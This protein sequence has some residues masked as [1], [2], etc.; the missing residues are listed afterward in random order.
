MYSPS[1]LDLI[2]LL[3]GKGAFLHD[4]DIPILAG[5]AEAVPDWGY[6]VEIGAAY[7]ASAVILLA[8]S[9][10]TVTVHSV[11]P[12]HIDPINHWSSTAQECRGA[13]YGA[14]SKL[15]RKDDLDRWQLIPE[16]AHDTARRLQEVNEYAGRKIDLLVI[17]GDHLLQGV[18]QDVHDWVGLVKPG[19]TI[20]L[21]DSRHNPKNPPDV[22]A[23]E[24]DRD[25]GLPGPTHVAQIMM[26]SPLVRLF[27]ARAGFSYTAWTRTGVD[28]GLTLFTTVKHFDQ[29]VNRKNQ[30]NAL[31]SWQK[32]TPR[33][34]VLV[35]CDT[36][37]VFDV[38][39][40]GGQP[41]LDYPRT[42]RGMPLVNGMFD[43]A[44]KMAL[45]NQVTFVNADITLPTNF[46]W[47]VRATQSRFMVDYM[48]VGQRWD[49]DMILW[50]FDHSEWE[51]ELERYVRMN[52]KLHAPTGK[53]FFAFQRP[54]P[55]DIPEFA[56]ARC[57]FDN[58]ILK[59]AI[60]TGMDVVDATEALFVVHGNHVNYVTGNNPLP[61][62]DDF[63]NDPEYDVNVELGGDAFS[64]GHIDQTPWILRA[65][66]RFELR[67]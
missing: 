34:Q 1:R 8:N 45:H 61:G 50:D 67:G 64:D 20:L 42:D 11:D 12:F 58:W 25:G 9:G 21:H 24:G 60:T 62:E 46:P 2:E 23:V 49:T 39:N 19:G 47:V 31:T 3:G 59:T 29:E 66:G 53:D 15:D 37:D 18:L 55:F 26:D 33:P 7:G 38:V 17:D 48:I 14:L 43:I 10:P 41:I 54:L 65:D 6:I 36:K 30:T 51:E 40:L 4:W 22:H 13:V 44:Q 57:I 56:I 27:D 5:A 32:M 52:G 63:H 16:T 28:A 35:F